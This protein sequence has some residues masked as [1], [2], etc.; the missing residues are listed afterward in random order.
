MVDASVPFKVI[1]GLDERIIGP[2]K[3]FAKNLSILEGGVRFT[4][5]L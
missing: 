1:R 4:S 3:Q 5:L 2:R